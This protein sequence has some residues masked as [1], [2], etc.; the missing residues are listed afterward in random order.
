MYQ[1]TLDYV[2]C[3]Y[4]KVLISTAGRVSFVFIFT[5]GTVCLVSYN[6]VALGCYALGEL[7]LFI[8]WS[9]YSWLLMSLYLHSYWGPVQ[10]CSVL[11]PSWSS[12]SFLSWSSYCPSSS[13][14]SQRCCHPPSKLSPKRH[15]YICT[16][17]TTHFVWLC[18]FFEMAN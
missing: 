12:S 4:W 17:P 13:S 3:A 14:S 6:K 11:S 16:A 7:L 9:V 5:L 18:H 2:L 8:R 10:T 15:V 1:G